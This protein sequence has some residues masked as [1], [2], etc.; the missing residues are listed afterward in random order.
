MQDLITL[1]KQLF[2]DTARNLTLLD[3]L[4]DGS[5]GLDNR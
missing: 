2:F 1:A 4:G 5:D 3:A